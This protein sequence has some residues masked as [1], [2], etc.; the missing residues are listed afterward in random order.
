LI[1]YLPVLVILAVLPLSCKEKGPVYNRTDSGGKQ[2]VWRL[3]DYDGR[4][5]ANVTYRDDAR[6]GPEVIY[7]E[8]GVVFSRNHWKSDTFGEYLDSLCMA[9]YAN[10]QVELESWY[11]W[12]EPMGTWKYYW[13]NGNPHMVQHYED[14]LRTGVWMFHRLDG[15][16]ELSIDYTG[17]G[18]KWEED[19][20]SG[21]HVYYDEQGDTLKVEV[22]LGGRIE[23][24]DD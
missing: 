4:L 3:Y 8:S 1:T 7:F 10:G 2:G 14:G 17:T 9:Y 19:R 23:G 6:Y 12:G 21:T 16:I 11:T 13:E 24:S 5:A 18:T 22:W 20:K 15:S